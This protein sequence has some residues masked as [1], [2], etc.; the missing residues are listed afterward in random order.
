[1]ELRDWFAGMVLQSSCR[2]N[3]EWEAARLAYE[4]ADAMLEERNKEQN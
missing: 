2:E 1:M 3:G 4:Y